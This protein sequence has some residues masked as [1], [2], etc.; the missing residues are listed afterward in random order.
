MASKFSN[1]AFYTTAKL[2]SSA[3]T[4]DTVTISND[5]ERD[6]SVTLTDSAQVL[7]TSLDGTSIE[8][9]TV[10]TTGG[11]LTIVER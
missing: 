3:G 5:V 2:L 6:A 8:R 11:T 9:M 10:T 4:G 7:F 1:M